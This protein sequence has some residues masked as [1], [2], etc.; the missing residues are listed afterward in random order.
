MRMT[1][2]GI[3]F[4]SPLVL[5]H[6]LAPLLTGLDWGIGGSLLLFHLS[7]V[8][9]PK[10]L[11]IVTT[12]EDFPEFQKRLSAFFGTP[13]Q[14]DHATYAST[15]FSRF[16]SPHGV[17]LDLMAG[18]RVRTGTGFKSWDFKPQTI[19]VES[20]LPWMQPQDWLELYEMFDRPER[21]TLLR[22]YLEK[23]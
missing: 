12:P 3:P 2:M 22:N 19:S 18:I 6:E 7:L 4:P 14:V 1:C 13:T 17:N 15:H 5:A 20:G 16:T 21:A 9:T 10:D 11:D 8:T 23:G